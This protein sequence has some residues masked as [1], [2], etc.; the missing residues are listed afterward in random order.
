[1]RKFIYYM[2][3]LLY[4]FYGAFLENNKIVSEPSLW[5][6]YGLT[7]GVFLALLIVIIHE[8]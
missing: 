5:V 8:E 1:M 4:V 6:L 2:M 3:L 7:F